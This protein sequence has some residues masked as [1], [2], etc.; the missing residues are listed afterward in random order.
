MQAIDAAKYECQVII[1]INNKV[2]K[3]VNLQ[4]TNSYS[5]QLI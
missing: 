2:S 5:G 1:G 4:V 3:E